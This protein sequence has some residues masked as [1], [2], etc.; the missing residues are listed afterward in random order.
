MLPREKSKLL[1]NWE[2]HEVTL[3][4]KM[5]WQ[6]VPAWNI[7]GFIP[8]KDSELSEELVAIS[9]YYDSIS[10]VPAKAPGAESACGITALIEIA[11]DLRRNPPAR[12]VLILATSAHLM[13]L[14]GMDDF[15]QKHLR[16]ISPFN[17][18]M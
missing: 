2:G 10:V 5:Q 6:S 11:R 14:R 17:E 3:K 13:G 1:K 7:I 18:N 15:I 4:A 16:K 9:A 12:P 8:G